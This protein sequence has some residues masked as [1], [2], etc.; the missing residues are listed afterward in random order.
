MAQYS[1]LTRNDVD[2]YGADLVDFAQRA[3]A[4]AMAPHLQ[5]LSEQNAALQ[6]QL[7]YERKHRL[8][9]QLEREIPNYQEIDRDSRWRQWLSEVDPL[10]GI[11][12]QKLLNEAVASGAA[13]RVITFFRG[14]QQSIGS[15][16]APSSSS[17]HTRSAPPERRTYT[18]DEIAKLYGQHRRGAYTGREA[19]WARQ[20][21][22]IIAAGREGRVKGIY[23]TK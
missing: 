14:F 6:Q 20:E 1:F 13:N 15:S 9:Q 16:Q 17:R 11:I 4:H 19:E 7:A 12:R 21:A 10:S 2:N 22:D 5:G 23:L 8:D 3:A 18:R